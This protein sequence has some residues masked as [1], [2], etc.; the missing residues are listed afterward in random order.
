MKSSRNT[1]KD[2]IQNNHDILTPNKI[3]HPPYTFNILSFIIYFF[4]KYKILCLEW[5]FIPESGLSNGWW[6]FKT[7]FLNLKGNEQF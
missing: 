6:S 7:S 4:Y 5:L 3:L 2:R 1:I